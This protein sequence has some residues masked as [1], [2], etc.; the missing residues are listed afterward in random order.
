MQVVADPLPERRVADLVSYQTSRMYPL[1]IRPESC[2]D[3][4]AVILSMSAVDHQT[5]PC[6]FGECRAA[7]PKWIR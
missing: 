1:P 5:G 2:A 3:D 4:D 7:G 6:A